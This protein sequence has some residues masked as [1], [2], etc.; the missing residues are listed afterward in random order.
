[1]AVLAGRRGRGGRAARRGPGAA[2]RLARRCRRGAA[3]RG[4]DDRAR[5]RDA[6]RSTVWARLHGHVALEIGGN[7]ASMGLDPEALFEAEVDAL[8]A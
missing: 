8:V 6:A 2:Q 7:F 1:M 3:T 5:G 4:T